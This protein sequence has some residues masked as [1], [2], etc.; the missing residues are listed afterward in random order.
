MNAIQH[1]AWVTT[2]WQ[3][4]YWMSFMANL[5][6]LMINR[7]EKIDIILRALRYCQ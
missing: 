3:H 1:A 5:V 4:F 6:S 7:D 2:K